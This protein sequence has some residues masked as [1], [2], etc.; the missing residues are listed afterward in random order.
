MAISCYLWSSHVIYKRAI[1][2]SALQITKASLRGTMAHLLML[3]ELVKGK[4][5]EPLL[6]IPPLKK[7]VVLSLGPSCLPIDWFV[8]L[9]RQAPLACRRYSQCRRSGGTACFSCAKKAGQCSLGLQVSFDVAG[10]LTHNCL[11]TS[12]LLPDLRPGKAPAPCYVQA[13]SDER[14][15]EPVVTQSPTTCQWRRSFSCCVPRG[16]L[17]L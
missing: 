5:L 9:A 4:G 7:C 16:W 1:I 3:L 2:S 14:P 11:G 15:V 8:F 6:P 13:D 12:L 17:R 10:Q